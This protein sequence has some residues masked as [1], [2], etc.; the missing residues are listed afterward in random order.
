LAFL[1]IVLQII[2]PAQ[3]TI[4]TTRKQPLRTHPSVFIT[5]ASYK[6]SWQSWTHQIPACSLMLYRQNQLQTLSRTH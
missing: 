3:M 2:K 4:Q 6:P 1:L 5:L